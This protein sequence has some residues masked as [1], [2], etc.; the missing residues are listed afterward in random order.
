MLNRI[1]DFTL[2]NRWMVM[3][4]VAVLIIA[5]TWALFTIPVDAFPDL[6]NNQVVVVTEAPSMPPSEVER[7]VTYPIE[8]ALLGLPKQI[9]V[10][11][12][13]KLG[14][15]MVTVV[16]E[17]S[18]PSYIARQFMNERLQQVSATLPQGIQP[19]LSPPATAFGELYQYTLEGNLSSMELKGIQEW[20]VK[21]QL[22]TI[23]GVSDINT[24]GGESKQ[25]QVKVDP[26]LIA[27]YGLTLHDLA[28][29]IEENN[30]NFGGGYIEHASEQYTL[31]GT[32]RATTP[33]DL[34]NIVLMA[35][36]GTPVLLKDV[37]EVTIGAAPR[38]GAVL[39]NGE[40]ISG[41]AHGQTA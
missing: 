24:W 12:L 8:V 23:P 28:I 36:Q 30:T 1:V 6:T 34:G 19:V 18:V 11:S 26:Q 38:K 32:G 21:N 9:E 17:D 27:Q 41:I 39:R 20:Q 16:F 31:R 29:R 13:S 25:F 3:A 2:K 7:L 37:A 35:K 14:L 10:R 4:A 40:T 5:G 22:R 15:S 33:Q